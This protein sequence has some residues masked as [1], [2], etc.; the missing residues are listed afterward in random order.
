MNLS[1]EKLYIFLNEIDKINNTT[2]N[3]IN[4]VLLVIPIYMR[5]HITINGKNMDN[6]LTI[7][8]NAIIND[9]V[10]KKNKIITRN[11]QI[12]NQNDKIDTIL[13]QRSIQLQNTT[14]IP[15]SI[16]KRIQGKLGIITQSV[17]YIYQIPGIHFLAID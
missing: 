5:P 10:N 17:V 13:Y 1:P 7:L 8:Y 4:K 6:E 16:T 3:V 12:K 11:D 9:I 2:R 14:K 15:Q